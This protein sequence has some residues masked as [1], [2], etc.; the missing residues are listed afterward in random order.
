MGLLFSAA[1]ADAQSP[2]GR[3]E[4]PNS[5]KVEHEELHAE[6]ARLSEAGGR[7]G[8]A[9]VAV[10]AV[11]EKHFAKENAYALPPLSLLV[12]LTE[13]NFAC[14]MT[15]VLSMTDKLQ[16]EMPT[17][18]SEHRE[19]VAALEKLTAAATAEGKPDGVRFAE[20]LT[21]HAQ[22]EEQITYP[23]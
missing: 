15:S 3:F 12:P 8:D 10:A 13:G 20:M 11:M 2:T 19:I 4:I 16:A 6:L 23:T 22:G 17:M 18:R 14:G 1:H 9:A 5:M 21:A 7:T